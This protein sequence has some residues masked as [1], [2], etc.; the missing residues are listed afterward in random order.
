[1][2][3]VSVRYRTAL[4]CTLVFLVA[5]ATLAYEKNNATN[6]SPARKAVALSTVDSITQVPTASRPTASDA[7]IAHW[8]EMAKKTPT[9]DR[10]WVNLGDAFMQKVRETADAAY[11]TRAEAAYGKALSVN[12][13]RTE[14]LVGMAWVNGGRHEFEKSQD[15]ANKALAVDPRNNDAY[16]LMGDACV[17]MGDYDNAFIQYQK[18]LDIR[19]DASSYSRGAHLLQLMGNTR[20]ASWLMQKA[21]KTGGPYAENTSWCRAQLGLINFSTGAYMPAEQIVS[22]GL[23]STPSNYHLLAAMGKIKAARKDYNAAISYYKRAIEVVPMIDS[24]VALGDLYNVTGNS[25][26]AE[27]QYSLVESIWKLNKSNGVRGDI[28]I[29][30]FYA[31]HDRNLPE[32]L[33]LAEEEVKTRKNVYVLDTLAWCYYKNGKYE[34]ARRNIDM[35]LS[36]QSPEALFLFHKGLIYGKCGDIQAARTA[37]YQATSLNPYFHPLF[38]PMAIAAIQEYGSQAPPVHNVSLP[39]AA[40]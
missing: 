21:I 14:A 25:R 20:K 11:Y 37:L 36:K 15:W 18:M 33:R 23:S 7:Q 30:Q 27:Q 19:P 38:A 24:V 17:E 16:G 26:M 39:A 34:D 8:A 4:F 31:D 40:R 22:E 12:P 5:V 35:A 10:A 3:R 6:R 28:Q 32:A 2:S 1:M 9:D 29:A 13:Q